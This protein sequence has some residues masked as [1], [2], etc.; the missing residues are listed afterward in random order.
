MIESTPL[1]RGCKVEGPTPPI[2]Y[3]SN[4]VDTV[5]CEFFK[6]DR[7]HLEYTLQAWMLHPE[8]LASHQDLLVAEF[9]EP[10]SIAD[11]LASDWYWSS[12]GLGRSILGKRKS[13][14]SSAKEALP[15]NLA[16]NNTRLPLMA[17][18][19]RLLMNSAPSLASGRIHSNSKNVE[20][21]GRTAD[22]DV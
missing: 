5:D 2:F 4:I 19:P 10:T 12:G 13:G 3:T 11:V 6:A 22:L 17:I 14:G 20:T 16:P 15:S 18:D 9:T 1:P 7:S 8:S 21:M